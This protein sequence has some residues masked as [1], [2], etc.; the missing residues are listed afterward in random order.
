MRAKEVGLNE[1]KYLN[2]RL[3]EAFDKYAA[4]FLQV[5]NDLDTLKS[6]L[7]TI[8][9]NADRNDNQVDK[10]LAADALRTCE[11]SIEYEFNRQLSNWTKEVKTNI[12]Q[13][14]K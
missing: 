11:Q 1:S 6:E 9:Y 14:L 8:W 7:H 5:R 12:L 10:E 4:S 3:Q 2:S 13:I